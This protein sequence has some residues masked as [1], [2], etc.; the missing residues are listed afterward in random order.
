KARAPGYEGRPVQHGRVEK[1]SKSK[2]NVVDPDA[3]VARYGA[4][5]VRMFMLFASP[6]DAELAWSD[7]GIEGAHRFLSRV[8]R[9]IR[10]VVALPDHTR[11]NTISPE[12][13]A[14]RRKLH[15]TVQRVTH[16]IADRRQFNTAIA[17]MMELVN[18]MVPAVARVQTADAPVGLVSALKESAD[19]LVHLLSPF[20]PHVADELWSAMGG[21]GFLLARHWPQA[22]AEA[23]RE[24][25]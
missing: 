20:A 16:D 22:D 10:D 5:T 6:P 25:D 23:A 18:E 12:A 8:Y 13:S 17:A 3:M 4:D 11:P 2:K 21:E 9:T 24:D 19:I 15:Q 1:M 7:A 14:L